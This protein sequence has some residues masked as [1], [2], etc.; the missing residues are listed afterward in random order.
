MKS[1]LWMLWE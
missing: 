1:D